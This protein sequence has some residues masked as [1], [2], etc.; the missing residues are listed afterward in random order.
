MHL[1]CFDSKKPFTEGEGNETAAERGDARL[2]GTPFTSFHTT[3][4][5]ETMKDSLRLSLLHVAWQ[6]RCLKAHTWV[7]SVP[8]DTG[9]SRV[10]GRAAP[11]PAGVCSRVWRWSRLENTGGTHQ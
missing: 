10:M 1:F 5:R 6:N 9:S 4:L 11:C 2:L 3:N 7:L 8:G